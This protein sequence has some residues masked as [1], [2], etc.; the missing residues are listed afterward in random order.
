V[1]VSGGRIADTSAADVRDE[2]RSR[3]AIRS[4]TRRLSLMPRS[5]C[6]R[7][8]VS[9]LLVGRLEKLASGERGQRIRYEALRGGDRLFESDLP[10]LVLQ[11]GIARVNATLDWLDQTTA[12][13]EGPTS[14]RPRPAQAR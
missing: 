5:P 11:H 4:D 9:G 8:A 6:L 12:A 13:L 7:T 14:R 2:A 1:A 3:R 10:G